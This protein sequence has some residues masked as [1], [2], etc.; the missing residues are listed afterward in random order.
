[1][2]AAA[3]IN[4]IDSDEV[5]LPFERGKHPAPQK[6]PRRLAAQ[7]RDAQPAPCS[8]QFDL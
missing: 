8:I 2:I 6:G 1:M 5:S 4:Q 3:L 7:E